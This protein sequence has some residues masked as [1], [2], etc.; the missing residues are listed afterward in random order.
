[1]VRYYHGNVA[2]TVAAVPYRHGDL[3]QRRRRCTAAARRTVF[4]PVVVFVVCFFCWIAIALLSDA[5]AR[6]WRWLW[7]GCSERVSRLWPAAAAASASTWWVANPFDRRVGAAWP[8]FVASSQTA[9]RTGPVSASSAQIAPSRRQ[10][11]PRFVGVFDAVCDAILRF[12]RRARHSAG[13]R[14]RRRVLL[15][16]RLCVRRSSDASRRSARVFASR[17]WDLHCVARNY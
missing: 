8:T 9:C 13:S 4:D 17:D 7:F 5:I 6:C 10:R 15:E 1:M 12:V 14:T 11:K 2:S 3:S 16:P